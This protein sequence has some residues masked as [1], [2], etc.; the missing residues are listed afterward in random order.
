MAISRQRRIADRFRDV[1]LAGSLFQLPVAAQSRGAG[2]VGGG[3]D[4]CASEFADAIDEMIAFFTLRDLTAV[5]Q[6][7]AMR[8][9]RAAP[10]LQGGLVV[11]KVVIAQRGRTQRQFTGRPVGDDLDAVKMAVMLQSGSDLLHAVGIALQPD[12]VNVGGDAGLQFLRILHTG[13]NEHYRGRVAGGAGMPNYGIAVASG[14]GIRGRC[15]KEKK[16]NNGNQLQPRNSIF[17]C[18]PTAFG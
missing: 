13:I 1:N 17:R 15:R 12:D 2:G 8:L 11:K 5:Q 4:R 18:Q 3:G 14:Y 7:V 10:F 9:Q 6:D 16:K